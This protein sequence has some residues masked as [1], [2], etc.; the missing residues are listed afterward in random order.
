MFYKVKRACAYEF[1]LD[2]FSRGGRPAADAGDEV[3]DS[4]RGDADA[5]QRL[6]DVTD[7]DLRPTETWGSDD[8][9]AG[10]SAGTTATLLSERRVDDAS[11]ESGD[12]VRREVDAAI[13]ALE[14]LRS[15][16]E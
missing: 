15:E 3:S 9:D 6:D 10:G 12:E 1:P 14:A 4:E 7:D 13:E 2:A 11:G 5:Q 16:G 8:A